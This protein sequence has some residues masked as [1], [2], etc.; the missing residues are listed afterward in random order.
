MGH[1]AAV[2]AAVR[3]RE[4]V[5]CDQLVEGVHCEA[6]TPAGA[7][8]AKAA[9][10]ALS[11]LAATAATPHA[12]LCALRAPQE[13]DERRLRG[14]LKA[15][16]REGRR[17]GAPL[18]GGD[19]TSGK[20]PLSLAVTAL[21]R[22]ERAGRPPGRDRARAGQV[23][24]LTGPVG[25]SGLGRHLEIRPRLAQG[26]WLD[27]LGA[28][29]LMDVSD[30]L[31]WDLHRLA[32]SAG[33]RIDLETVPLHE[34]AHLAAEESGEEALDH[35]LHDGEDHELIATLSPRAAR[36]ALAAAPERCPELTLVGRVRLGKGLWLAL[37]GEKARRWRPEEGG[38]RHGG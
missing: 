27:S 26:R 35:A 32:R 7:I 3:G 36:K 25:G 28:T 5:C 33:A 38:W 15:L 9:A 2:L 1:D 29:A 10:R 34:D 13:T 31:A 30:G 8:G 4:V 14:I 23:V 21:G 6:G 37:E 20:G 22:L 11:D 18:V 17:H 12:L 16:D 24:V 19:L